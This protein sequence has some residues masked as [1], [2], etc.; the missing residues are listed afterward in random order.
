MVENENNSR[1]VLVA[2]RKRIL[3]GVSLVQRQ[4]EN[5]ANSLSL[6]MFSEIEDYTFLL[7]TWV[8]KIRKEGVMQLD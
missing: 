7:V 6:I 2:I 5:Y 3:F 4:K 8:R 1:V